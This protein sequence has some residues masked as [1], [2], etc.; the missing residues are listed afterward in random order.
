MSEFRTIKGYISKADLHVTTAME[1]YLEMICRYS[2]EKGFIRIRQ[3]AANLHVQ[4]SSASKMAEHL[5]LAG[6]IEYEKYGF[7]RPTPSGWEMGNYLL[8]RHDVL[9]EFLCHLNNSLDELEQVEKIEHFF[10][11][12]TI[13][14]L[15]KLTV[16]LKKNAAEGGA[17]S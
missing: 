7:I 8:H 1:D 9:N 12:D 14:N 15:E 17:D 10:D 11:T 5:K 3:L 4:P 2:R 6:Y 16:R 13:N